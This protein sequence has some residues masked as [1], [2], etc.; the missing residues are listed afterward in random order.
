[1]TD[2]NDLINELMDIETPILKK[3]SAQEQKFKKRWNE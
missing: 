2:V 1:M 3:Q